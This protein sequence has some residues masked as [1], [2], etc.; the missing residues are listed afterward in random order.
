M[1]NTDRQKFAAL[2]TGCAEYYGKSVSAPVIGLYWKG[3][4]RFDFAAVEGAIWAHMSSPENGQF[5][6]KIADVVL[7]TEGSSEDASMI[8]W[9]KVDKAVRGIGPYADV[10]FDDAIIHRVLVEMG[11]W[12]SLGEKTDKEWPFLAKEFQTRYR[13]YRMRGGVSEYQPLLTGIVNAHNVRLGYMPESPVLI[14]DE[15][16]ARHVLASGKKQPVLPFKDLKR[17]GKDVVMLKLVPKDEDA[18]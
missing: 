1:E 15:S 3:L 2:I 10:V 8:A 17:L 11:G 6:P 18:A 12:I 9:T 16:K 14:G 13:G 4:E 5:M 7:R